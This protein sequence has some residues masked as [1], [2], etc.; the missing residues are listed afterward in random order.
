MPIEGAHVVYRNVAAEQPPP[1]VQAAASGGRRVLRIQRQ[2]YHLIAICRRNLCDGFMSKRMPVAHGHKTAHIQA[3]T[4]QLRFQRLRLPLRESPDRRASA[5]RRVVMLH[6]AG[7]RR[8]NQFCKRF[9][10]DARKREVNNIGVAKE[11]KKKWLYRSQRIGPAE[12]K[13]NYSHT[14][15]CARHSP[16]S[17]G[18][19]NLLSSAA[20]VNGGIESRVGDL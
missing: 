13:Q 11:I 17:P 10:P 1:L 14:P 18:R 16:D 20:R 15:C 2:Q 3:L 7:P 19:A 12:L 4:R 8:R 6:L 9:A 5:N